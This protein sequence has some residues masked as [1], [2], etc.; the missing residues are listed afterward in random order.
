MLNSVDLILSNFR[1]RV[2]KKHSFLC[3]Y[4]GKHPA[5]GHTFIQLST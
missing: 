3:S 1:F 4:K 5:T 2:L